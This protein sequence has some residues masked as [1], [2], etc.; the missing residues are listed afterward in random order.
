MKCCIWDFVQK[1]TAKENTCKILFSEF[2]DGGSEHVTY[3]VVETLK[4]VWHDNEHSRVC[5]YIYIY[6]YIYIYMDVCVWM[7]GLEGNYLQH[8]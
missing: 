5:V 2:L 1:E 3:S 8:L 4:E 7:S 6:I